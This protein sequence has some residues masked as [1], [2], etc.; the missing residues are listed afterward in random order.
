MLGLASSTVTL[1][2]PAHAQGFP[3]GDWGDAPEGGT[4]YPGVP[5]NFPTCSGIGTWD[6]YAYH[7]PGG[8]GGNVWFGPN[9]DVEHEGNA[10]FCVVQPYEADECYAPHDGD[11]G[12]IMPLAYTFGP[13]LQVITCAGFPGPNLGR[14]CETARW[15]EDIDITLTNDL[16]FGSPTEP[17]YLNV[18]IDYDRNGSWSP[19]PVGPTACGAQI[20]EHVVRNL[21]VPA[22]F[23][24]RVSQ[25]PMADF[26][27]G[28]DSGLVWVRFTVTPQAVQF[29]F[30]GSGFFEAGETEDYLMRIEPRPV[31]MEYGDAP[32]G[33]PAYPPS[34]TVGAFP[35]CQLGTRPVRHT[36][37]AFL[38]LGDGGD[39]EYDGNQD[40]CSFIPYDHDE[41][42]DPEAGI[43]TAG[44]Y[45]IG[46][47]GSIATCSPLST[48]P[49]GAPCEPIAWGTRIDVKIQQGLSGGA[50]AYL[51]VLFDWDRDGRW[52]SASYSCPGGGTVSERVIVNAPVGP[53]PNHISN[54]ALP[55]AFIGSTGY[56][57]ARF[58]VSDTPVPIDWD[59]GGEV[60]KGETEDYLLRVGA[61]TT[62][63]D[64][65][66]DPSGAIVYQPAPNPARGEAGLEY[67]LA[68]DAD[69]AFAVF[70]AAGRVIRDLGSRRMAKGRHRVVWDGRT[71][72][73]R[74]AATGA[75][76]LRLTIRGE[77]HGRRV[78]LVH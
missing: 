3:F 7:A 73:G 36:T 68:R 15:G 64:L 51:N 6:S 46:A 19:F 56:V 10:N 60:G 14:T 40:A 42:D 74:A 2:A 26:Q 8:P 71:E 77:V 66:D 31:L 29:P 35:T 54:L 48:Q 32:E 58:T 53:G 38:Y 24:G 67:A 78:L 49:M 76:F 62:G 50:T 23:T 47:N 12:L 28:P 45:T 11:A 20:P 41:C 70:D 55:A 39:Y 27:L 22:G 37:G 4:A 16:G 21:L 61:A 5:G 18:L 44:V 34:L 43:R 75:Y 13:N 69:V 57:W 33:V 1:T 30:D 9:V 63:V 25:L 52:T 65:F 72:S 59:G 17:A